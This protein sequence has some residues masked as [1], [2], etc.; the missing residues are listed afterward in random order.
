MK[1]RILLIDNHDSFTY[2]LLQILEEH[3]KFSID[4]IKNDRLTLK[5]IK[6]YKKILISPGPGVPSEAKILQ[7]VVK[8]FFQTKSILG[9]CLGHQA[10]AE[11][12]GGKL[13]NL[14]S[15]VHGISKIMIITDSNDYLFKGIPSSFEAGLYHSWAVSPSSLPHC[16]KISAVSDDEVV[17]AISHKN[18]DVKGIQF[19]PESIITKVGKR[20][21][22]NWLNH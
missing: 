21:L 12:F 11:A 9:V 6:D 14:N 15:V 20:I 8:N 18:Y 5:L 4:V 1:E 16:I 10:I 3:G 2:N 13:Y 22:F 17:M 19:H 7:K